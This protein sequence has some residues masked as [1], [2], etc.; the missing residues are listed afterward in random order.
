MVRAA[1]WTAC[2]YLAAVSVCADGATREKLAPTTESARHNAYRIFNGVHSVARLWGTAVHHNGFSFIPGVVPAGTLLY[3]GSGRP[4]I[5]GGREWLAFEVEHA[6]LF[7]KRFLR[8]DPPPDGEAFGHTSTLRKRDQKPLPARPAHSCV[9]ET[10]EQ[11]QQSG[12]GYL[13][14]FQARRD[15]NVLILDGMSAAY[16]CS[17]R[18]GAGGGDLFYLLL[19]HADGHPD[20]NFEEECRKGEQD[21]IKDP[22]G[23]DFLAEHARKS[24]KVATK[25]GFDALLRAE[26]GFELIYCDFQ[27]DGLDLVASVAQISYHKRLTDEMNPLFD[28]TRAITRKYDGIGRDRLRIDF[29]SMVSGLFFPFNYSSPLPDD[30]DRARLL[31]AGEENWQPLYDYAIGAL[32]GGGGKFIVNWQAVAESIVDRYSDKLTHLASPNISALIFLE[33]VEAVTMTYL[34]EVR[35]GAN[36]ANTKTDG[37]LEAIDSCTKMYLLPALATRK[38][39]TLADELLHTATETVVRSVCEDYYRIY[40][41]LLESAPDRAATRP[42]RERSQDFETKKMQ[43]AVKASQEIVQKLVQKLDWSDWRKPRQCAPDEFLYIAMSPF[44]TDNDY[45]NPGCRSAEYMRTLPH[46]YW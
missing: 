31:A 45:S 7:T 36:Q 39:W 22:Y 30:P 27:S 8:P 18:S 1:F 32:H 19:R 5:P 13:H 9:D 10:A 6:E 37:M 43:D 29:S 12:T 38:R 40:S 44:G 41:L 11:H 42:C 23:Y 25:L 2:A 24:C 16:S 33:Q 14:T 26:A 17:Q 15:L 20:S 4:Q 28:W 35:P 34:S 21:A 46:G 3:H